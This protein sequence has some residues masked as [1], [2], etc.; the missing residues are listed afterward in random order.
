MEFD[1]KPHML[2]ADD[3]PQV[4]G[5]LLD[6]I[7]RDFE[8]DVET[9][10]DGDAVLE[11]LAEHSY[12]VLITDMVMPGA[13]GIELIARAK[14]TRPHC[15]IIVMT[16]YPG[17]FP[18]IDAVRA[19]ASDF[20][21]KPYPMEEMKARL[22]RLFQERSLRRA[23]QYGG[24]ERRDANGWADRKYGLL[25]EHNTNGMIILDRE[26]HIILD[27]NA[28]LLEMWGRT[29]AQLLGTGLKEWLTA[30]DGERF[31]FAMREFAAKRRG[32]LADV[33]I[34][35][36]AGRE[37]W[38]DMSITYIDSEE[39]AFVLLVCADVTEKRQAAERLVEMATTD[40]L[41]G[42][43]NYRTFYTW[44]G[45]AIE[46]AVWKKTPV[47]LLFMDVDNFKRCNDTYGHQ[48]GDIV[49]R[50]VGGVIRRTIRSQDKAFR[51]GGDEFAVIV[52]DTG[53]SA[54]R[55]AERIRAE[56]ESMDRYG[57]SL[58]FGIAEHK[59]GMDSETFVKAADEAL[60][61]AKSAGK[62]SIHIS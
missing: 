61:R 1:P 51:Y 41:T 34:R 17:Q 14:K 4:A 47:A 50:T 25:F 9:C 15:D 53:R 26:R 48:T 19:G 10:A 2:I 3:E 36:N 20:I 24:E 7:R 54:A 62:N 57:T 55:A 5:A 44:L 21:A 37:L 27:V 23:L 58:S 28:A 35:H 59:N 49:L 40:A 29:R 6:A 16:A 46:V 38:L 60:Y 56:F 13:H 43:L 52:H 32:A 22:L 18:F 39:E 12:D 33:Q 30:S 8:C 42:L 45:G 11:K 31:D